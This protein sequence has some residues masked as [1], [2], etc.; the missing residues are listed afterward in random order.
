LY[1]FIKDKTGCSNY[2]GISL[3]PTTYEIKSNILKVN[4]YPRRN[5]SRTDQIFCIHQI[6]ENKMEV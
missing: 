1:L 4:P 3:L 5:V 2:K 6:L